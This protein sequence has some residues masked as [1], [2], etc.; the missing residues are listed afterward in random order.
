[1]KVIIVPPKNFNVQITLSSYEASVLLKIFRN[2]SG[3]LYHS[4]RKVT[5]ELSKQLIKLGI[6]PL[7]VETRGNIAFIEHLPGFRTPAEIE[8]SNSSAEMKE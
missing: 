1:M 4:P 3:P 7:G 6:E 2:I 8:E 5:D